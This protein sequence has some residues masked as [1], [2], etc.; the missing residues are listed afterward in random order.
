MLKLIIPLLDSPYLYSQHTID[1]L[2]VPTLV[3]T[4]LSDIPF[5]LIE[6]FQVDEI[7]KIIYNLFPWIAT[8]MILDRSL[9]QLMF[10]M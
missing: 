4:A 3:S 5:T 2:S 8:G 9:I 7:D 1:N 10:G 6:G